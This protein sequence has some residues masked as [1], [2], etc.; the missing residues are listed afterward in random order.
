MAALDGT[1]NGQNVIR[2]AIGSIQN[3]LSPIT[4]LSPRKLIIPANGW[5]AFA[6]FIH[7]VLTVAT[8]LLIGFSIR[9]R[10]KLK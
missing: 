1:G 6:Q 9:R 10:H 2:A 7:S 3:I 4:M 5:G 8:V